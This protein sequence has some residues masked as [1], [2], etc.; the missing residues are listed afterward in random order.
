[1][2]LDFW[3]ETYF[4]ECVSS[5][6]YCSQLCL[7]TR[8]FDIVSDQSFCDNS[9]GNQGDDVLGPWEVLRWLSSNC[10]DEKSK[11]RKKSYSSCSLSAN[12]RQN[13]RSKTTNWRR[14]GWKDESVPTLFRIVPM[15]WAFSGRTGTL[16][17]FVWIHSSISVFSKLF[18]CWRAMRQ[19]YY[20]FNVKNHFHF[21]PPTIERFILFLV[22][23]TLHYRALYDLLCAAD[24]TVPADSH[25][26]ILF[27]LTCLSCSGIQRAPVWN[28]KSFIIWE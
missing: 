24:A 17:C 4:L 27:P 12:G 18:N 23:D 8:T 3:Q 1:M 2:G 25:N 11:Q 10:Q 6:V 20:E 14:K 19:E 15:Y 22:N 13:Q 7:H 16:Q 5:A 9:L 21:S 26:T 28:H